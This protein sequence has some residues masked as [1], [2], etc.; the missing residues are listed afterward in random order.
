MNTRT[1]FYESIH[2]K[3]S[4]FLLAFGPEPEGPGI[5]TEALAVR[6]QL[7]NICIVDYFYY[8]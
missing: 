1:I 7:K 6:E 3:V 5:I 2:L 4:A 8:M